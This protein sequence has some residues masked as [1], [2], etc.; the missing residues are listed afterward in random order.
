M[1][2]E[3]GTRGKEIKEETSSILRKEKFAGKN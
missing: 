1:Q 3:K 2:D